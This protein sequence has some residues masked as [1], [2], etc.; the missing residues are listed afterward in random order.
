MGSRARRLA[1][2]ATVRAEGAVESLVGS[3]TSDFDPADHNV[4]DVLQHVQD[5]PDAVSAVVAAEK[6]GKARKG[7]LGALGGI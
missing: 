2:Q 4:D 5:N 6:A 7:I 1:G 3:G